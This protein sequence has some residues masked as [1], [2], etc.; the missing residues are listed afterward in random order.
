MNTVKQIRFNSLEEITLVHALQCY[1]TYL[2]DNYP[3][4]ESTKGSCYRIEELIKRI[5]DGE[6][7]EIS[8]KGF[9]GKKRE[10]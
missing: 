2:R 6:S 5:K 10:R 4:Q 7:W 1:H 9:K 8:P 3:Q